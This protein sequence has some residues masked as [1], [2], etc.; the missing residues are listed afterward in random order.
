MHLEAPWLTNN[1]CNR[2]R[3]SSARFLAVFMIIRLNFW[4]VS[5]WP[6]AHPPRW[7]VKKLWKTGQKR[8]KLWN[9]D[10]SHLKPFLE[11][12]ILQNVIL[13]LT[14]FWCSRKN[15]VQKHLLSLASN[16]WVTMLIGGIK[17]G[18]AGELKNTTKNILSKECSCLEKERHERRRITSHFVFFLNA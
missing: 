1:Y 6:P 3:R 16:L 8:T 5:G 2:T 4:I 15:V 9:F 12:M 17:F 7:K 14:I 11:L 10:W 13:G 18:S